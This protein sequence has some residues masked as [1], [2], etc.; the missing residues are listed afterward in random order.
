LELET[1]TQG[2]TLLASGAGDL[3]V[4]I[5]DIEKESSTRIFRSPDFDERI[6]SQLRS[7]AWV[8]VAWTSQGQEL[9]SSTVRY[10]ENDL[11][12][13]SNISVFVDTGRLTNTPL[14]SF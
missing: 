13:S 6:S 14:R 10:V 8:P 1:Q 12:R 5:W 4:R 2:Y 7:K 3:A 9:L 11:A